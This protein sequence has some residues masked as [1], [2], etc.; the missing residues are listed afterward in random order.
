[1]HTLAFHVLR[2]RPRLVGYLAPRVLSQADTAEERA[3]H[4]AQRTVLLASKQ[5]KCLHTSIGTS[6]REVQTHE[7]RTSFKQS[8][9]MSALLRPSGE[10]DSE[11]SCTA[12]A[13]KASEWKAARFSNRASPTHLRIYRRW[14]AIFSAY[15]FPVPL[16]RTLSPRAAL[17]CGLVFCDSC[18]LSLTVAGN[19]VG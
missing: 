19:H 4:G 10:S 7:S 11:D 12:S 14:P 3:E 2:N 5:M 16:H 1:M 9:S 6:V 17:A 13:A 8:S 18:L 15:S